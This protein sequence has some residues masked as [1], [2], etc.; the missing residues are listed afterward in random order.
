M[1]IYVG[2]PGDKYMIKKEDEKNLKYKELIIETQPMWNVKAKVIT[3]IIG[4]T[5]T[6]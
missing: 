1:S 3:V 2:I 4:A 5:R 6:I